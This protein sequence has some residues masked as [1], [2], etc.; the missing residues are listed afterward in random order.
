MTDLLNNNINNSDD[1]AYVYKEI[2]EKLNIKYHK[3]SYLLLLGQ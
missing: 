2:K 3:N 1:N